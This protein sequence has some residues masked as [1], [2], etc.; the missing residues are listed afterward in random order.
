MPEL[1]AYVDRYAETM[2]RVPLGLPTPANLRFRRARAAVDGLVQ[3]IVDAR[4]R[5][6]TRSDDLLSMLLDARDAETGE[7]MSDRQ[8]RDE[9]MTLVLAG[10]ETTAV[11]LSWTFDLL[12]RHPAVARRLYAE[13]DDVL[14]G[15]APAVEDLPN[16]TY[17]TW[18]ILES[19]RLYP[20]VWEFDRQAVADDVIDGYPVPAGSMVG[21]CPF[22][23]HRDPRHWVNPEGFEPERFAP[24]RVA[25]RSKYVYLPF[26]AGPRLCIGNAFAMMEMQLV[27]AMVAQRFRLDLVPGHPTE[28]DPVVTLRPR[29]GV[30]VTPVP[31][32]RAR[33]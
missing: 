17:T 15:R 21:V 20:P 27:I 13:V 28:C 25:S 11:A 30:R 5:D 9:I 10:H 31:R 12:S 26:G 4:R 19:M 14:A 8:L 7:G 23:L 6:G 1:L 3:R 29:G 18:V 22:A 16:L 32:T 24:E 33:S 2:F